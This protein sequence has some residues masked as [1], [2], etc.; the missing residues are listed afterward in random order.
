MCCS[1]S[2]AF[3]TDAKFFTEVDKHSTKAVMISTPG[4]CQLPWLFQG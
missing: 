3:N 4:S 2:R 1:R